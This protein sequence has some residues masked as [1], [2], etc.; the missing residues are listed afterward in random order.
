MSATRSHES[1]DL[2]F[3]GSAGDG[4][5]LRHRLRS[6][7]ARA[8][9]RPADVA[10]GHHCDAVV[11]AMLYGA[12]AFDRTGLQSD[13]SAVSGSAELDL[14][15]INFLFCNPESLGFTVDL[16]LEIYH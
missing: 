3:F 9:L 6:G 11:A 14:M 2:D 8:A 13:R 7:A 1:R 15:P 12:R 4:A 5:V 16:A 10:R